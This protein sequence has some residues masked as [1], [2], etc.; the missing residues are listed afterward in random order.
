MQ[1]V[2]QSISTTTAVLLWAASLILF[3]AFAVPTARADNYQ[4]AFSPTNCGYISGGGG[5]WVANNSNCGTYSFT[6]TVT[7]TAQAN[8]FDVTFDVQDTGKNGV[9]QDSLFTNFGLTL[10]TGDAT[11]STLTMTPIISGDAQLVDNSKTNNGNNNCGSVDSHPGTIC[12]EFTANNG[13]SLVGPNA[14][15]QFNFQVTIGGSA[16]YVLTD[17]NSWHIMASGYTETCTSSTNCTVGTGNAYA[18]TN[19][20]TPTFTQT[21]E[22]A[23]LALLGAGILGLA[24]LV[25]RRK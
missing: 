15:E 12:L 1:S 9:Y 23:S 5:G 8:V 25:R 21:P 10:F 20:G 18:L 19:N 7:T 24:G 6:T 11:A 16:P 22:P 17:Y 14:H 3:T 13:I 4:L 2:R